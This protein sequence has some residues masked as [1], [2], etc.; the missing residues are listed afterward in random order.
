MPRD[1]MPGREGSRGNKVIAQQA[2]YGAAGLTSVS[3]LSKVMKAQHEPKLS[4]A[5]TTHG[6]DPG[7]RRG[8]PDSC[9]HFSSKH[10]RRTT[11]PVML[12]L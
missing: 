3:A 12:A 7:T 4:T 2:E 11:C 8:L 5:E 1:Q 10:Q 6:H 9:T